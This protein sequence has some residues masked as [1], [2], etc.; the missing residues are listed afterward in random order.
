VDDVIF[1]GKFMLEQRVRQG[2][3]LL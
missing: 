3:H 2:A 1:T